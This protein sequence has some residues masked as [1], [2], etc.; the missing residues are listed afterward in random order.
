MRI[1]LFFVTLLVLNAQVYAARFAETW[2]HL[3]ALS[4]DG[5]SL[6]EID[7]Q[8]GARVHHQRLS[9][10]AHNVS[11]SGNKIYVGFKDADYYEMYTD[12]FKA[13]CTIQ[14]PIKKRRPTE[15]PSHASPIYFHNLTGLVLDNRR[16]DIY[17]LN[18]ANNKF[19]KTIHVDE[20]LSG[21]AFKSNFAFVTCRDA[22]EVVVINLREMHVCARIKGLSKPEEIVIKDRYAY[23]VCGDF[24]KKISVIDT[25][26][27][28]WLKD[29]PLGFCPERITLYQSVAF[30][31]APLDDLI[32]VI[33]LKAKKVINKIE[34]FNILGS[35][36]LHVRDSMGY[37]YIDDHGSMLVI[38]LD[39][40]QAL[41]CK[42]IPLSDFDDSDDEGRKMSIFCLSLTNEHAYINGRYFC[43]LWDSAPEVGDQGTEDEDS[44]SDC[45]LFD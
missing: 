29:I 18:A 12:N 36:S 23:V 13:V 10:V 41:G 16:L 6:F 27:K 2:A 8:T 35:S 45:S 24:S 7:R 34:V 4:A 20:S 32:I 40:Q 19:V 15:A 39:F 9:S 21:I 44:D 11:C 28:K 1:F 17:V 30:V 38:D 3:Y 5:Y 37:M 14:L 25:K 26:S 43:K 22:D 42:H 33:D 31:T